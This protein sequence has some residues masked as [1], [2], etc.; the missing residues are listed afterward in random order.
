MLVWFANTRLGKQ[1]FGFAKLGAEVEAEKIVQ[2]LPQAVTLD[3]GEGIKRTQVFGRNVFAVRLARLLFWLP[4]VTSEVDSR[5]T[6]FRPA[7]QLAVIGIIAALTNSAVPIIALTVSTFESDAGN[8]GT[9]TVDGNVNR[10]GVNE[11]LA[12]IRAGAGT[13]SSGTGQNI[14]WQLSSSGSDPNYA[15]LIRSILT[16]DTSAIPDTDT[17]S[18]ARLRLYA[19]A[20]SD[21]LSGESSN[22]SKT[23]LTLSSP[24]ANNAIA[25][26]D[27]S[28]VGSTD[29]GRSDTQ[30]NITTSAYN[31]ITLNATG[32]ANISKT[33]VTPLGIR[34][35]WDFDNTTT[36]ITWASGQDQRILFNSADNGGGNHPILEVT[37]AASTSIKTY[38]GLATA[39]VKTVNGL[40]IASV[41]NRNGL[42]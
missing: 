5:Q 42:A 34:A 8:P 31:D 9:T 30:A 15:T 38:D 13:G 14:S 29:L 12:V 18:S 41:K 35:A 33:G 32:L 36:G 22:N 28:Q 11:S 25:N 6:V 23:V 17:I 1:F 16:F 7:Y 37:H 21:G 27:F 3:C 26:S 4:F 24:A 20:K 19:N 10:T 2:L 40:A 39:S